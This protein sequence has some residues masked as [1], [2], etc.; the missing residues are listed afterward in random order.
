MQKEQEE[1]LKKERELSEA[2]SSIAEE[3]YRQQLKEEREKLKSIVSKSTSKF[4]SIQQCMEDQA[5]ELE[6]VQSFYMQDFTG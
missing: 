4:T 1:K 6:A 5:M 3:E 2:Q